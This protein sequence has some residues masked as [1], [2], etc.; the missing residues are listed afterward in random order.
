MALW[1]GVVAGALELGVLI[2]QNVFLDRKATFDW[3]RAS[4]HYL[5]MVPLGNLL[6]FGACG[7]LLAIGARAAGRGSRQ[8]VPWL[9]A[10]GAFLGPLL[11]VRGL[12]PV[13]CVILAGGLAA[14]T[15]RLV[16][17]HGPRFRRLVRRSLP[18]SLG[19]VALLT[20]VQGG[21]ILL[22]EPRALASLPAAA[23]GAPNV[24]LIVL[25]TVRADHLSPYGY[26]RDTTPHLARLAREGIRFEQAR[27]AAPW[28]LPSHATMFTGRWH[29]EHRASRFRPM[30]PELPTLAEFLRDH[31]YVTGGFVANTFFCNSWFGLDKGFLHYEDYEET[32][33]VSLVETLRNAALGRVVLDGVDMVLG[34]RLSVHGGDRKDAAQ[35]NGAALAWLDRNPGRP[36]FA[37][38]NYFDAHSPYQPPAGSGRHFGRKPE[39]PAERRMIKDWD[40]IDKHKL[41]PA[42]VELARDAYDACIAYLDDRL[43]ALLDALRRRDRLRNTLIVVTSDHGEEFGEHGLFGHAQSLYRPELHVPL[44]IV[45]PRGSDRGHSVPEPVSLRNLPATVVSLLGLD[46]RSPFPGTPLLRG[47]ESPSPGADPVLAEADPAVQFPHSRAPAKRGPMHS[48][49]ADGR[50]YIRNADGREELYDLESDPDELRDLTGSPEGPPALERFRA[51][52]EQLRRADSRPRD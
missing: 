14:S 39:S 44:L 6:V 34:T 21:R 1:F 46:A 42:E 32:T 37:F 15:S 52:W 50:V 23:P 9:L 24:L 35:L 19:L 31:G 13:A 28:T 2:V 7:L 41:S 29:H 8:L 47:G 45:D 16:R 20:V 18:A 3:L 51:I 43:A 36:F 12:Y 11:V 22:A 17:D 40:R 33:R 27:A 10:F 5:W 30:D 26:G 48:L 38:L 49:V 4:R 25:D